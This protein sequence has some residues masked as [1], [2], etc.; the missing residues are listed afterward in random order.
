MTAKG[1]EDRPRGLEVLTGNRFMVGLSGLTI[2]ALVAGWGYCHGFAASAL[3]GYLVVALIP[4][5]LLL[6]IVVYGGEVQGA[7]EDVLTAV[8]DP[9]GLEP[10]IG[11]ELLVVASARANC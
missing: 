2:A 6:C 11:E 5:Q 4:V 10:V 1:T 8:I 9:T 3:F 7:D